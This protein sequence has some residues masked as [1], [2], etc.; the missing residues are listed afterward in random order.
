MIDNHHVLV[1]ED[2]FDLLFMIKKLLELNG[3]KVLTANTGKEGRR[4]FRKYSPRIRTVILDLTLP[5]QDGKYICQEFRR[6]HPELPIIITTGSE[7]QHQKSELEKI[8]IDAF[9]RKPFDLNDLLKYVASK[10]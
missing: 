2:D 6:K 10:N 7:D 8:G 5:D 4:K 9:L 3:F 1:I